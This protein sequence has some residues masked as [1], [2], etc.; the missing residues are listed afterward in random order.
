MAEVS[1]KGTNNPYPPLS[2]VAK[3]MAVSGAWSTPAIMPQSP[4]STELPMG[5]AVGLIQPLMPNAKAKPTRAPENNAGA[6]MPATPPNSFGLRFEK[7]IG[8]KCIF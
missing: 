5:M 1:I 6:K 2:S 7:L 3:K 8:G 4:A